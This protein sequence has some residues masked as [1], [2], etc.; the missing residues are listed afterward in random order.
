MFF[1]PFELYVLIFGGNGDCA[2]EIRNT[3]TSKTKNLIFLAKFE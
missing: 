3:V 1:V 2:Y